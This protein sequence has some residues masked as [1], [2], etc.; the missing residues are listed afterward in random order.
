MSGARTRGKPEEVSSGL[1][2]SRSPHSRG[3]LPCQRPGRERDPGGRG[4]RP[5]EPFLSPH[6]RNHVPCSPA[7]QR[8]L[9][10]TRGCPRPGP[11]SPPSQ[12]QVE[13]G[14]LCKWP[15]GT[16]P[17]LATSCSLSH[18]VKKA[19][20]LEVTQGGS[21]P[22]PG[23]GQFGDLLTMWWSPHLTWARLL[24][25]YTTIQAVRI[26]PV[27]PSARSPCHRH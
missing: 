26:L 11:P 12:D 23:S 21:Q 1:A 3:S 8:S 6:F 27:P 25:P 16:A 19:A 18:S 24:R 2:N 10:K 7:H 15:L 5:Q 20:P 13:P 4:Q 14:L 17:A 22:A 9:H